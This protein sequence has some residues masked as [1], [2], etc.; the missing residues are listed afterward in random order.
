MVVEVAAIREEHFVHRIVAA[1][2]GRS[3]SWKA[4]G[5]CCIAGS[6]VARSTADVQEETS[7]HRNLGCNY[8]QAPGAVAAVAVEVVVVG[9]LG[10][11]RA[12]E[13]HSL[14]IVV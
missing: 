9:R 4:A 1:G 8:W 13:C 2:A 6:V 5:S 7:R 10:M 12:I 14:D 11:A 3:V